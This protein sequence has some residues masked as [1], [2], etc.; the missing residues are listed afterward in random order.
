MTNKNTIVLLLIMA[1]TALGYTNALAQFVEKSTDVAC[2]VPSA[3]GL[4]YTIAH[5]DKKGFVQLGFS[6]ASCLAVNYTMEALITKDRPDGTGHH[7][8]PSTHT[9]IAFNGATFLTRRYGW[10]IGVPAYILASYVAWGRVHA[11]RHDWW[12]VMG[13]AAVG[14]GTALICTRPLA[15]KDK[16]KKLMPI[17][18]DK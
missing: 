18:D 9:A 5:K 2:L 13:G 14:A 6:T 4:G 12:D 15:T 10:R 1:L 16:R 8:F 7:A 11:D 17:D 3:T